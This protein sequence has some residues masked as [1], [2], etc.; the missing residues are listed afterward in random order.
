MTEIDPTST[1]QE[2]Q[3]SELEEQIQD[4]SSQIEELTIEVESRKQK[5]RVL[6]D[7]KSAEERLRRANRRSDQA[8]RDSW[9]NLI[10]LGDT[11]LFNTR[12]LFNSTYGVVTK[13]SKARITARDDSG[14]A[15]S[16]APHNVT[17]VFEV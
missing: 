8:A 16:R 4:L 9:G 6:R 3:E 13:I 5:L 10:V 15:I 14:R 12:G 17:V 11:V 7:R 2:K 1:Q